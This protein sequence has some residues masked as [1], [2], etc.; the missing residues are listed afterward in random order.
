ML[1]SQIKR[2]ALISFL[3]F[4]III[5]KDFLV[6]YL[7][8]IPVRSPLNFYIS[9]FIIVPLSVLG[10]F[11]SF[12]IIIENFY[13]KRNKKKRLVDINFVLSLPCLFYCLFFIVILIIGFFY[14]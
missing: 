13:K 7:K 10:I 2:K 14:L 9:W 3:I 4:I 11:F 5:L 12:Q 1:L 8:I 6:G